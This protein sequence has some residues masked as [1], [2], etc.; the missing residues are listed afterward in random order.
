M[1]RTLA[2][3]VVLQKH[4]RDVDANLLLFLH[5]LLEER[6]LTRA[7]ARMAM[8]QPAMSGA[9]GRL[10]THFADDLLVRSGRGFELT[11][12]AQEI[13]PIVQEAVAAAEQL[14]GA[15]R[16]FDPSQSTR[17]FSLTMSEYAMSVIA[18]PLS[19]AVRSAAPKCTLTIETMPWRHDDLEDDLMRRDLMVGPLGFDFPGNTQPVFTDHL[20]CLVAADLPELEGGALTMDQLRRIPHAVAELPAAGIH[21]RPLERMAEEVGLADRPVAVAVKSLLTLPFAIAGTRMC[22]FVPWRLAARCLDPLGLAIAHTPLPRIEITEAAHWHQRRNDDPAVRWLRELLYDIAIEL[23]D[24]LE[25][26]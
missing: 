1:A 17:Q 15:H 21:K 20:V 3:E 18:E 22:A 12:L 26:S 19:R 6:N 7:G 4:M 23:E 24:A 14:L 9:L 13:R 16:Q 2:K 5:A 8:S 25:P 10:R 11:P